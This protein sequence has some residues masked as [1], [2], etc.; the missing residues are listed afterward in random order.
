MKS[1]YFDLSGTVLKYG[2]SNFIPLMAD[3]LRNME[4]NGWNIYIVSSYTQMDCRKLLAEAK[5]DC[6][7][8][9]ASAAGSSKG[10]VIAQLQNSTT[11][12]DSIFIDDQPKNL[13]SV[14]RACGSSVRVI[15]FVGSRKYTPELSRWC[16]KNNVELALSPSDLCEGLHV[17]I[18]SCN[19][20]FHSQAAW[21]DDDLCSLI[22]GLDHPCSSTAG[23]SRHLDHRAVL[24][25]LLEYRKLRDYSPFWE[26][27]GWITCNECLWKALVR[28]VLK[29]MSLNPD[30]VLKG[31]YKH[32][33][34]TTAVKTFAAANQSIPLR[35]QFDRAL[36]SM[37]KGIARIGV[38]AEMCRIANR[39]IERDRLATAESRLQ[40][41]FGSI[42][43]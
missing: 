32:H 2:T 14:L 30:D 41:C 23:E 29:S 28:S 38:E 5:L 24:C 39:P 4:G 17:G 35:A 9:I 40:E 42:S 15:G 25:E 36:R 12:G 33:E 13:D 26:N 7:V 34:Y 20:L 6:H 27:I 21:S 19:A 11:H 37:K 10:E 22:P 1:A 43:S 3:I 31:A 18:D 8:R 16:Q